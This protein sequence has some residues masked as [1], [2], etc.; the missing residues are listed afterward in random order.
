MLGRGVGAP[1]QPLRERLEL[2]L[3]LA[4]LL[5]LAFGYGV[6]VGKGLLFPH[7]LINNA[8]DAARDWRENWRQY[9][10]L[11]S[12]FVLPSERTAGGVTRYDRAAAWPGDTFLT[13]FHDGHIGAVLVDMEG[14]ALH[15][16]DVA[17]SR[18]WPGQAVFDGVRLADDDVDIHGTALLPNGDAI[19]NLGEAG[20]VRVDRCSRVLWKVPGETHHAVDPLTSGETLIPARHRRTRAEPGPAAAGDWAERV[21]LGG[22]AAARPSGQ[23]GGGG[24]AGPRPCCTRAAGRPCCS[25]DRAPV[26]P[27]GWK[28]RPTSTTRR[29]CGTE[30]APAFPMFRAG[31]V[32]LSLRNLDTLVVA[33]PGDLAGQ[34]GDDRAVPRPAL[35]RLPAERPPHGLRQPR[36]RRPAGVRRQPDPRDRPGDAR[37]RLE[38]RRRR[39]A[40]LHQGA[41]ARSRRCRTGTC[42]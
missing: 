8:V 13:M 12:E 27:S 2:G 36:D 24:G 39:R 14:R 11:R 26:R 22:H 41:G 20:T 29:C 25:R 5:A 10:G 37:G 35:P 38:L 34:V 40:V 15:R 19:L 32:L 6:A 23:L 18:V 17:V 7:V 30:V 3:F 1:A 42:W 28:I 21:L 4:G 33:D 9:L 16:W 31:D